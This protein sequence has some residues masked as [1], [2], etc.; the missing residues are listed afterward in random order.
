MLDHFGAP[1][2]VGVYAGQ[3]E[4][5]F[6]ARQRDIAAIAQSPNVVAK[7]GGLAMPDNGFGWDRRARPASSDELVVAQS[8]YYQHTIE[9]FGPARCM[10][11]S[12]FPVDKRSLPCGAYWN[13][14]KKIAA[15]YSA[16]EQD[17]MFFGTAQRIYRL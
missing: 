11:E 3:R 2:G 4:A 17:A 12:N 15:G 16:D 8:R 7:L 5:I 1:L 6:S 9:C 13:A 10:F 14:M